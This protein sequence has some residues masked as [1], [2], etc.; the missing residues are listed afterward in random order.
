MWEPNEPA[1]GFT[2]IELL[3]AVTVFAILGVMAY[4]GLNSVLSTQSITAQE[5]ARL[6]ALQMS[7][8]YLERD[9][10]QFVNRP[11]RNQFGDEEPAIEITERPL[12]RLTHAGWQ[13]PAGQTRSELQRVAYYLDEDDRLIRQMWPLL[14]GTDV[15][16]VLETALLENVDSFAIRV[17]ETDKKWR[18]VWPPPTAEPAAVV[19]LPIAVEISLSAEPWG[20][21]R[22]LLALPN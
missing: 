11:I 20:E 22:R 18:E 19:A 12:L 10:S 3:I 4:G 13:N 16:S 6:G 15:E 21:L 2:L 1:Q 9:V 17:M 7:L 8:R 14:D 5:S